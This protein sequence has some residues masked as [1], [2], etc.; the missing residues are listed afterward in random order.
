MKPNIED[1]VDC[2]MGARIILALV[3]ELILMTSIKL[4]LVIQFKVWRGS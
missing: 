2:S 3:S 4:L 1:K